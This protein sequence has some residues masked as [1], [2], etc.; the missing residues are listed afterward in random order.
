MGIRNARHFSLI[1]QRVSK[2]ASLR[3]PHWIP[4]TARETASGW[5]AQRPQQPRV[6]FAQPGRNQHD[7]SH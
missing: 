4:A 5:Q 6:M 3:Q 2:I 1:W 7:L